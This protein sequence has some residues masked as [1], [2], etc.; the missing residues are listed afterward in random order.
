M[1]FAETCNF[2]RI[3]NESKREERMRFLLKFAISNLKSNTKNTIFAE[4]CNFE[5]EIKRQI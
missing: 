1:I 3:C 5:F 2:D 4:M